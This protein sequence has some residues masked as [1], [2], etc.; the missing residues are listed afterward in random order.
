MK[1]PYIR[2][3]FTRERSARA[4]PICKLCVRGRSIS[5][6]FTHIHD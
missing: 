1:D 3:K 5:R 6:V 2:E 4:R